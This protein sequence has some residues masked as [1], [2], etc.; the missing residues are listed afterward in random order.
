L[1]NIVAEFLRLKDIRVFFMEN[2][3][4]KKAQNEQNPMNPQ[5]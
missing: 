3:E 1:P 4:L 5:A 2:A